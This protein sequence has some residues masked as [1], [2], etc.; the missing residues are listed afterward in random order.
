MSDIYSMYT[1]H[2]FALLRLAKKYMVPGSDPEDVVQESLVRAFSAETKREILNPKAFLF[3]VTRNTALA[4]LR[5]KKNSLI[6]K[7]A[8]LD[9]H[10]IY[11][12]APVSDPAEQL[13]AKR[14]LR[15]FTEAVAQLPPKCR[16]AFL[17]RRVDG[18][19]YKQI[20]N[21]MNISVSAVEKH[22]SLGLFRCHAF[23]IKAG[24]EPSEFGSSLKRAKSSSEQA[25]TVES[26]E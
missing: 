8:D 24:F 1:R 12:E 11:K 19:S 13:D 22:V 5:N 20:A 17:L 26:N 14:K 3:Q 16:Q 21:R 25:G 2:R 4:E 6:E 7:H 23:L 15:V 9:T 18:L 10:L